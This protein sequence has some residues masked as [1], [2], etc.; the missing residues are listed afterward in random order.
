MKYQMK[1]EKRSDA[2]V[3]A[4]KD[5]LQQGVEEGQ[6]VTNVMTKTLNKSIT[7]RDF[8]AVET[9]H[10]ILGLPLVVCSRAKVRVRTQ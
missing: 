5:I 9:M 7:E 1:G 4:F 3:K 2:F 10:Q 8:T 6:T